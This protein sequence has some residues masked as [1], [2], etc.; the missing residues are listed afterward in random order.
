VTERRDL[1]L[2]AALLALLLSLFWG[3]NPVA[4]KLG[5]EDAPPLRLAWMRF[6]VGGVVIVLGPTG[7]DGHEPQYCV[8][9]REHVAAAVVGNAAVPVAQ[10]GPAR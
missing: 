1:D 3:G 9:R 6:V 10:G 5:L 7:R 4:I 8:G 2:S